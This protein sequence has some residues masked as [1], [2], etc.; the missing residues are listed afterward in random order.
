MKDVG[1][2]LRYPAPSARKVEI[3]LPNALIHTT[4]NGKDMLIF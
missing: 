1:L 2:I 4:R 3:S